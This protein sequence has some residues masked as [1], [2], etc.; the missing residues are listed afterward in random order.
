MM[1]R[2]MQGTCGRQPVHQVAALVKVFFTPDNPSSAPAT[3]PQ[4]ILRVQ[5]I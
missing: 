5:N 2:F 3:T 1:G 4:D